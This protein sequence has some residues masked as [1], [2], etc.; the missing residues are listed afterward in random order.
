MDGPSRSF[1]SVQIVSRS[2]YKNK[3]VHLAF[4]SSPSRDREDLSS[5]MRFE[6]V[7]DVI[8]VL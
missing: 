2:N 1:E 4:N 5:K 7:S 6:I 3:F 8:R